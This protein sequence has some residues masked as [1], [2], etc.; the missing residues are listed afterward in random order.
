[1]NIEFYKYHGAGND[2]VLLD[3]REDKYNHLT[4]KDV[5]IL[6]HRRFG[7][8]SD[9]MMMLENIDGYD[10]KMRYFNAD[11]GEASMCGNGGRCIVAFAKLLGILQKNRTVFMAVDGYHEAFIN[12]YNIVKLRMTDIKSI[13]KGNGYYFLNTGSPHYVCYV[14]DIDNFDVFGEGEKIRYSSEFAPEGTNVNFIQK[15][16]SVLK[17]RTYERGVEDE[18]LACGTGATASALVHKIHEK[19]SS[20]YVDLQALG[21][22]LKVFFN[23]IDT[24][25]FTNIWLEGPT[26]FIFKGTINI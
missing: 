18:T 20:N 19:I 2:F 16:K 17:I 7:I 23:Q 3:N 4:K 15:T 14:E 5:A 10:F 12:E 1:M 9:G 22:K 21:G 25:T 6:C 24:D 13:K 8:G 11:G 26:A